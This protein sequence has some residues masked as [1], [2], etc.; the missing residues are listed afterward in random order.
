MSLGA[1]FAVPRLGTPP[2]QI[3]GVKSLVGPK[4]ANFDRGESSLRVGRNRPGTDCRNSTDIGPSTAIFAEPRRNP[5]DRLTSLNTGRNRTTNR[6]ASPKVG[7]SRVRVGQVRPELVETALQS[8]N[9]AEIRSKSH[10]LANSAPNRPTSR[11]NWPSPPNI[12]QARR[13]LEGA[14]ELAQFTEL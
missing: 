13:K 6:P 8:T 1:G 5:L 2:T 10:Q 7:R 4:G 3:F 11:Q 14:P 9:F 12:G